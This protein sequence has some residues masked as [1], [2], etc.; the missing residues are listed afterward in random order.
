MNNSNAGIV[1]NAVYRLFCVST[2]SYNATVIG[3]AS[4]EGTKLNMQAYTSFAK[5]QFIKIAEIQEDTSRGLL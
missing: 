5:S 1:K 2:G 4:V 3:G